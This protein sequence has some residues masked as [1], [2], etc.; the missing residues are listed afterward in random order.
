MKYKHESEISPRIVVSCA[1][2]F[3]LFLIGDMMNEF[4]QVGLL[5]LLAFGQHTCQEGIYYRYY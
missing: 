1:I 3:T 4:K 5:L 2:S